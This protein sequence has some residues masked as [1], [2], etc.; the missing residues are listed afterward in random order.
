MARANSRKSLTAFASLTALGAVALTTLGA[1]AIAL[2]TTG[3]WAMALNNSIRSNPPMNH[4][5]ALGGRLAPHT[6]RIFGPGGDAN[7]QSFAECYRRN[8]L[9]LEKLDASMGYELISATARHVCG[10]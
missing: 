9:R 3:A 4:V 10:A 5:D 6:D 7:P 8:Y 1:S 2:A